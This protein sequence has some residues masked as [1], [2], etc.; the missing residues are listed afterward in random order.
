MK[1]TRMT[2]TLL[3]VSLSTFTAVSWGQATSISLR[4]AAL[5]ETKAKGTATS[6][7]T[8]AQTGMLVLKDPKPE[9][10]SRPWQYIAGFTAQQFQA[11][12]S[13]TTDA[14]GT[15]DLSQN[16]QTFMPGLMLGVM[17]SEWNLKN[18]LISGGLRF[19][20]SLAT[21]SVSAVM[22][23]GVVVE[24]A[25]LNTS[26]LS[27]GVVLSLRHAK[28]AWVA[29][30]VAPQYGTVNYTQSSNNDFAKFSKQ[31]SYD[32]INYG[33]DF[34]LT[35]KWSV[36][37]EWSQRELRDKTEIALQKDNFELGTKVSW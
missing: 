20:G 28:L 37:T 16:G 35:K 6:S 32:A 31:A 30:T 27:G 5:A 14:S 11:K 12:G 22:P 7:A 4:D 17:S 21:Q 18:V 29:V 9:I 34:R 3:F 19:N 1:F 23:S 2:S 13:V 10:V 33:L 8:D 24:D 26:L 25:R 36:F 15:F